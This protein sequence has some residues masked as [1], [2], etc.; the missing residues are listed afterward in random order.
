MRLLLFCLFL[1]PLPALAQSASV[2]LEIEADKAL[3]WDEGQKQYRAE[4]NAV[5]KQGDMQVTAD[6][7]TADYRSTNGQ[8]DIWQ[9]TATGNVKLTASGSTGAGDKLVYD[10]SKGQAV[11]TGQNL[12]M[13]GKDGSKVTAT[14]RFEYWTVDRRAVAVGNAKLIQNQTTLASDTI[15]AWLTDNRK[16][17]GAGDQALNGIDRAEASG[18]VVITTPTETIT[19]NRGEYKGSNNTAYLNGNVV[20]K[21]PPNTLTGARAEINLTTNISQLFAGPDAQGKPGRVKGVFY[22]KKK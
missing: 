19:A 15:T 13:I 3:I 10:V 4:G 18:A 21:R 5:A 12:E 14:D 6:L 8:T 11:L 2:P 16:T 17:E 7:L 20:L 22:P 9:I 1:L